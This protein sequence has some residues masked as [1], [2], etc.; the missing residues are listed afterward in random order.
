MDVSLC[1]WLG[2]LAIGRYYDIGNEGHRQQQGCGCVAIS[3]TQAAG[4]KNKI[5]WH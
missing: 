3:A 1:Y 2:Y 5:K 4:T